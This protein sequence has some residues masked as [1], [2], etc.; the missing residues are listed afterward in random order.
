M[1]LMLSLLAVTASCVPVAQPAKT[2]VATTRSFFAA[3]NANDQAVL[4]T[5][6][7]AGSRY[8]SPSQQID[9]DLV[10]TL[11]MIGER[12][13]QLK[14][15]DATPASEKDS[16]T[17]RTQIAGQPEQVGTVKLEGGCVTGLV[18]P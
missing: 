14:L 16:V 11:G 17:I 2:D 3:I 15:I 18:Q 13:A 7:K 9:F 4:G 6:V 10:E 5:M 1:P 8:L 12:G